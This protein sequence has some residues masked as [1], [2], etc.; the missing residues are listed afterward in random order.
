MVE[1]IVRE[2]IA[3]KIED[4]NHLGAGIQPIADL[5]RDNLPDELKA[6]YMMVSGFGPS[7]IDD[8]MEMAGLAV[9]GDATLAAEVLRRLP[10][11]ATE[12]PVSLIWRAILDLPERPASTYALYAFEAAQRTILDSTLMVSVLLARAGLAEPEMTIPIYDALAAG[13]MA[14]KAIK[15][16]WNRDLKEDFARDLNELRAELSVNTIT[17]GSDDALDEMEAA[18]AKPQPLSPGLADRLWHIVEN[19]QEQAGDAYLITTNV[20]K[21][22]E[23]YSDDFQQACERAIWRHD[24]V[25]ES[26]DNGLLP[27][28]EIEDLKDYEDGTLGHAFYHVIVDNGFD[29]EVLDSS[30]FDVEGVE[31]PPAIDFTS[32]RILQ[33][34]D[35]WHLVGGYNITPIHE[36]AISGFQLAQFGQNYSAAFLATT[37][38]I[39]GFNFPIGFP[40]LLQVTF[41]GWRHGR[42]TP[43]LLLIDWHKEWGK[44]ID[45]IR[46]EHGISKYDSIIDDS[47][48][49]SNGA[50]EAVDQA[51][52]LVAT[53]AE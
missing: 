46:K 15:P 47:L 16:L 53:A 11:G 14:G 40:F 21:Y 4:L 3:A 7:P 5:M 35:I 28:I 44:S 30:Q 33:S 27:K 51:Q 22:G 50:G 48:L 38:F 9:P 39:S 26:F 32:R 12:I 20:A 18:L 8:V 13:W 37:S 49:P 17:L 6:Q 34:H 31:I 2:A 1:P 10:E 24:G 36:V 25:K 23:V 42:S 45:A 41:E 43:P 29:V 52:D 19:V